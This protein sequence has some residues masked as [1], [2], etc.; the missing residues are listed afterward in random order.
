MK[1][2]SEIKGKRPVDRLFKLNAMFHKELEQLEEEYE[3]QVQE[4]LPTAEGRARAAAELQQKVNEAQEAA[5]RK[6]TEE[7]LNRFE[8]ETEKLKA[9]L[10]QEHAEELAKLKA[11]FDRVK[12]S[13]NAE[14]EQLKAQVVLVRHPLQR[15]SWP[16]VSVSA[17]SSLSSYRGLRQISRPLA[18]FVRF[19]RRGTLGSSSSPFRWPA[20]PWGGS[21]SILWAAQ[22][23]RVRQRF[24]ME[25]H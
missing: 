21:Y 10:G 7:L 24:L 18:P 15:F 19:T 22:Y 9:D 5:R 2:G 25:R 16:R 11:E 3:L 6:V 8:I 1:S 14:R 17:R 23:N 4:S 20:S 12:T 13:W